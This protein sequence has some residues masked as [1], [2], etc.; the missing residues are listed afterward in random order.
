MTATLND[1]VRALLDAPIPAVLATLNPDGGPQTSVVWVGRDGDDVLLSTAAGRRKERNLHRDPRAS[2]TVYDPADPLRYV[3]IRGLATV[4]E[5]AGR[6]FA[7]A[8]AEQYEG[9]GAGQEYL[10]LPPEVTRVVVRITP[11]RVIGT[12]AA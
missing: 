7:A 10:D 12:A 6:A 1:A 5:D 9:P 4:T 11:T 8:L 2:L 3:E